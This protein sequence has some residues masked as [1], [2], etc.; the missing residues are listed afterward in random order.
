M[1]KNAAVQDLKRGL[2][3]R[4]IVPPDAYCEKARHLGLWE[5]ACPPRNCVAPPATIG[6]TA[7]AMGGGYRRHT[8]VVSLP[9]SM[10]FH[11]LSYRDQVTSA[12]ARLMPLSGQKEQ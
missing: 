11:R 12:L 1:L 9:V 2:R 5:S 4:L 7:G 8:P 10:A 6:R 3:G